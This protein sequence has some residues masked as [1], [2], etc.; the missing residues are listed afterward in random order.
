MAHEEWDLSTEEGRRAARDAG[1]PVPGDAPQE[2]KDADGPR[3]AAGEFLV[4][5]ALVL[6]CLVRD[7]PVPVAEYKFFPTRNWRFDWAWPDRK[8][9]LEVEGGAWTKGRHTRGQGFLDDIVKYN[10][11]AIAGWTVLR[12]T[13][14]NVGTGEVFKLLMAVLG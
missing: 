9:A 4:A 8:V 3:K 14:D 2:A 7:L 11:A 12:C 6:G 13:P 1:L 10:A 5:P